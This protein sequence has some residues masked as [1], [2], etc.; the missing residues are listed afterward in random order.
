MERI[1][2]AHVEELVKIVS[3]ELEVPMVIMHYNDY[4]K[5]ML[6]PD[7]SGRD[8]KSGSLREIDTY[9]RGMLEALSIIS[10]GY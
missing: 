2:L 4:W 8:L 3:K 10:V 9:L 6:K 5:L 1:K 7:G